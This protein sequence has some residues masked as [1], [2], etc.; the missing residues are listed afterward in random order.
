MPCACAVLYCHLWPVPLYN[1]WPH[2]LIDGTIFRKKTLLNIKHVFWF[3]LQLLSETFLILRRIQRDIIINVH[4]SSCKMPVFLLDFNES[5]IFPTDFWKILKF[6]KIL[7]SGSQRTDGH[8]EFK[9]WFSEFCERALTWDNSDDDDIIIIIIGN[10]LENEFPLTGLDTN[11]RL[12]QTELNVF[13]PEVL[14]KVVLGY[15]M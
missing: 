6:H 2:H 10:V 3:S 14:S 13:H 7:F 12:R 5:W 15:Y 1:I 4:R 9:S 11:Q 8:V